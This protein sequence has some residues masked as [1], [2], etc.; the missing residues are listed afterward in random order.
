MRKTFRGVIK[1]QE[2]AQS[3]AVR[4]LRA[5][6]RRLGD[7]LA[8]REGA[9]VCIV[10]SSALSFVFQYLSD[11]LIFVIFVIFWFSMWSSSTLP[12]EKT[13]AL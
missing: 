10:L 7:L 9:C 3:H 8:S 4:D 1:N 6:H 13:I 12:F 11:I 2:Q 5:F